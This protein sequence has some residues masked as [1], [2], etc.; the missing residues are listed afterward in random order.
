M[1]VVGKSEKSGNAAAKCLSMALAE[2]VSHT[3]QHP[4]VPTVFSLVSKENKAHG[5]SHVF[6]ALP[7]LM[8]TFELVGQF[9]VGVDGGAETSMVLCLQK[10]CMKAT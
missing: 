1:R 9:Q 10:L 2:P 4:A 6:A 3:S 5:A 7:S 8:I